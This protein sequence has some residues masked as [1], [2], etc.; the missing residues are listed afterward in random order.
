MEKK[1]VHLMADRK[2]REGIDK[3]KI[4]SSKTSPSDLLPPDW[5][6]LLMFPELPKYYYQL[7]A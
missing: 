1:V 3:D 5:P 2:Q 6:H 7:G 4:Q